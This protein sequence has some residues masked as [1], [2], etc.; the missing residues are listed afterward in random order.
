M[1]TE[2]AMIERFGS[3]ALLARY[4]LVSL[5]TVYNWPKHKNGEYVSQNTINCIL[6]GRVRLEAVERVRLG[7]PI[8][9][10]EWELLRDEVVPLLVLLG[11]PIP[12]EDDEK[13][14]LPEAA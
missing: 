9:P 8:P 12:P 7:V 14:E 6:A 4:C 2:K 1:I 5:S 11:I 13:D 3:R 10:D